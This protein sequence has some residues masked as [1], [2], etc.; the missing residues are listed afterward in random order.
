MKNLIR[1]M[2]ALLLPLAL[3]LS[4][5]AQAAVGDGYGDESGA[6]NG[7]LL[8]KIAAYDGQFADLAD[9]NPVF[10]PYIA[11]SYEYGLFAGRDNGFAPHADVT[12]AELLTLSARLRAAYAGETIPAAAEGEVWYLPYV[13]YLAERGLLGLSPADYDASATRAEL[14]GIFALSLPEDCFDNRNALI[15]TDA[16]ASGDYITDVDEY[17]PY[18]PQILWL[19]RQGVLAGMDAFGS[20]WPDE[21]ASRAEVAAVVTRMVDPS[22]RIALDWETLPSWSAAGATLA[23]L[24]TA[25]ETAPDSTPDYNDIAAVE[26]LVRQM[27]SDGGHVITLTYPRPL[28]DS[29][30]RTLA[31]VFSMSVKTF[32]EQMYN[33]VECVRYMRSG[34]TTL[35]FSAT[36]CRGKTADARNAELE[37]YR[38][39]TMARAIEVHDMLWETGQLSEDM[40]EREKAWVYYCWLC[41]NCSYDYAGA[42]DDYSV[43]HLAYGALVN[44][45]AVCDGYTGAYNLFL[46]LEGVECYA[47]PKESLNHIWTVA[48]LDGV[49]CHIDVTWGDQMNAAGRSAYFAMTPAQSERV[50]TR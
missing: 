36:A 26:T 19:Y 27:L 14:A 46:K 3:L 39:A 25:P 38:D 4:V 30:A 9:V 31:R 10:L 45:T 29:D 20:Y 5:G 13:V 41:D 12:V 17:T 32:C 47:L 42:S 48:T 24:V 18:Q 11:A 21:P 8:P 16:Y 43:S 49:E 44:G 37:Q 22:L 1:R 23:S 34:L 15:V 50:H 2:L 33:S 35:I 6:Q 7:A 28:A 40:S